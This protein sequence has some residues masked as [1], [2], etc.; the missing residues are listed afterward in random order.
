[1]KGLVNGY[2]RIFQKV[3]YKND[4]LAV[5]Y[6]KEVIKKKFVVN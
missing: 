4:D 1:M 6:K 2:P 3:L 5:G